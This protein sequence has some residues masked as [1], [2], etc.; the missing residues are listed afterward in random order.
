MLTS[1]FHQARSA[2]PRRAIFVLAHLQKPISGLPRPE[3]GGEADE[4]LGGPGGEGGNRVMPASGT[5]LAASLVVSA[6]FVALATA[7]LFY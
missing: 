2:N 4:V 5:L 1:D 7:A 6:V 3:F